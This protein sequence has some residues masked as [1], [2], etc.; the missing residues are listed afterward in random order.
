MP[1]AGTGPRRLKLHHG[2]SGTALGRAKMRRD[3]FVSVDAGPR[4]ARLTTQPLQLMGS[5]PC[6]NSDATGGSVRSGPWRDGTIF[7]RLCLLLIWKFTQPFSGKVLFLPEAPR[8][9]ESDTTNPA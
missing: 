8:R 3:G 1:E 7:G 4:T 2:P 6:V 9:E 5:A